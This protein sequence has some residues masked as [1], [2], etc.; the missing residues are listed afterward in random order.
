[1]DL[2]GLRSAA[3]FARRRLVASDC[4]ASSAIHKSIAPC[5]A[6]S[7]NPDRGLER[8]DDEFRAFGFPPS[9]HY[10]SLQTTSNMIARI[11]AGRV[12]APVSR[13]M[14]A[15]ARNRLLTQSAAPRASVTDKA[16]QAA[17]SVQQTAQHAGKGSD[18]PWIVGTHFMI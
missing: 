12:G 3:L 15:A 14:P 11:A 17:D 7:G 13:K 1:M 10:A 18:T 4:V 5:A 16:K 9:H 2:A 6:C 8:A